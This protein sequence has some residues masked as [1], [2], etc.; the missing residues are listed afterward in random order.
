MDILDPEGTYSWGCRSVFVTNLPR[1][2]HRLH[3]RAL[4]RRP[5]LIAIGTIAIVLQIA[6][7][8]AGE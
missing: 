1:Q 7:V 3:V 8:V 4:V 2:V 6:R 5:A